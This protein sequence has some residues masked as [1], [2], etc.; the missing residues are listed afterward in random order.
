MK[1][2]VGLL[3]TIALIFSMSIVASASEVNG[4]TVVVKTW[5]NDAGE[6]VTGIITKGSEVLA[7]RVN[8]EDEDQALGF[9]S[10]PENEGAIIPYS[11]DEYQVSDYIYMQIYNGDGQVVSKYKVTMTGMVSRVSSERYITSITFSRVFGDTCRT[12][13]NING[14]SAEAI[15][16]HP[17]EGYLRANIT[18]GTGGS[19]TIY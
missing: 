1:K 16:T 19:F 15:I 7:A 17:T 6:N 13:Y 8:F 5:K 12:S 14:Y 18:L 3:L 10:G 11:Y 9:I 2:I 4:G